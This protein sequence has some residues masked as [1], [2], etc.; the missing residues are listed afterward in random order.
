M[1][2][3]YVSNLGKLSTRITIYP[4]SHGIKL[5]KHFK[6]LFLFHLLSYP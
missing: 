5:H 2:G 6:Y 4:K 1:T 3:A